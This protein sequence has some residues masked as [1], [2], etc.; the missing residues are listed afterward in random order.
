MIHG[1]IKF[2]SVRESTYLKLITKRFDDLK[3]EEFEMIC[4]SFH[5]IDLSIAIIN[6]KRRNIDLEKFLLKNGIRSDSCTV[7]FIWQYVLYVIKGH[8]K[9]AE[10]IL[11]MYSETYETYSLY[12]RLMTEE[13]I[14]I[15]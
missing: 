6:M 11:K 9:E 1:R 12:L 2:L 3:F 8:W 14:Q 15:N 10:S 5:R 4:K 13:R 7:H